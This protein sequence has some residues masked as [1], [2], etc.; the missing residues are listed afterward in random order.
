MARVEL[1]PPSLVSSSICHE[2]VGFFFAIFLCALAVAGAPKAGGRA[3]E[4][5]APGSSGNVS[6]IFPA[7]LGVCFVRV[8]LR[9]LG[10]S[11]EGEGPEKKRKKTVGDSSQQ[12]RGKPRSPGNDGPWGLARA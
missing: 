11:G 12:E 7:G 2:I 6:K 10:R 8:T 4:I 3:R 1:L 5:G 9:D